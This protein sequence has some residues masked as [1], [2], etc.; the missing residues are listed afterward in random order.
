MR[1]PNC[2][3]ELEAGFLHARTLIWNKSPR[4]PVRPRL[5]EETY[6]A[7][8]SFSDVQPVES[9][10]C[11]ECGTLVLGGES[12]LIPESSQ[13][14]CPCCS[15]PLSDGFLR[16][17]IDLVWARAPHCSAGRALEDGSSRLLTNRFGAFC[18]PARRCGRCGHV[19]FSAAGLS[20]GQVRASRLV[21]RL[22]P[23][24]FAFCLLFAV[25]AAVEEL[26][27]FTLL[28]VMLLGLGGLRLLYAAA[29]SA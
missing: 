27:Y 24:L 6:L 3:R 13:N 14:L 16:G 23:W 17:G 28:L 7:R 29:G 10:F 25:L 22:Y 26:S 5:P 8:N 20:P 15:E 9:F 2:G 21:G 12:A 4:G 19:Y 18:Y 11:E 1:C